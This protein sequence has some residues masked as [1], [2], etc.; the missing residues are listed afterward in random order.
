MTTPAPE[1]NYTVTSTMEMTP[2][3]FNAIFGSIGARLAA[4]EALEANFEG[5][6]ATGTSAALDLILVN[7]AP[8]LAELQ[9]TIDDAL[10]EITIITEGVAPNSV[11]LDSQPAT[12][13]LNPA[14]FSTS[15]NVKTFMAAA[16][17]AAMRAAMDV[18]ST[19]Q[20]TAEIAAAV[21]AAIDGV[22]DG[23]P[24]ALDT[25]NEL[26]AAIG[27]NA[28]YAA[29]VT[30]ALADK[31]AA[32]AVFGTDNRIL[33]SDGTGRGAQASG[34]E[35]DDNARISG[36]GNMAWQAATQSAGQVS[37]DCLSGRLLNW[38]VTLT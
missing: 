3:L 18:P 25:L 15:A 19:G 35:I 2:D 23:A 36:H 22:I 21:S 14:N 10:A 1:N 12:Y 34:I 8:Q 27:D 16:N 28:S 5:L 4:R 9:Q 20:V 17:Y 13:Y 32:A 29:A 7:I 24:G 31:V 11:L 6:I 30:A 33:R 26:A 37:C 38:R